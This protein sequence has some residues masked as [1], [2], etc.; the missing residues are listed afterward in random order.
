[1]ENSF[2]D[3]GMV[4]SSVNDGMR[5]VL[6]DDRTVKPLC[7]QKS[8][9]ETHAHAHAHTVLITFTQQITNNK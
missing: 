1:M 4:K 2:V 9:L 5:N 6:G 7:E 8:A 3:R